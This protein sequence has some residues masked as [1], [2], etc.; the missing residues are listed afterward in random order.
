MGTNGVSIAGDEHRAI[1][2]SRC[3]DSDDLVPQHRSDVV[4]V[5]GLPEGESAG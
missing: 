2:Y 3:A 1:G 5:N 4:N